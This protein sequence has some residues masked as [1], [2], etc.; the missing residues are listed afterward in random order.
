M[1][2]KRKPKPLKIPT[3][4]AGVFAIIDADDYDLV[5]D[6]SWHICSG[7]AT[8]RKQKNNKKQ[9]ILMHKL[10]CRVPKNKVVDHI[11][12]NKLDNR[13]CNLRA[14]TTMENA[15]N[16][17]NPYRGISYNK[18]YNRYIAQPRFNYRKIHLGSFK[19]KEE[20]LE[21]IQ[22]WRE[23][24]CPFSDEYK[25]A[26]KLEYGKSAHYS[27]TKKTAYDIL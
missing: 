12:R 26:Q 22:I 8:T 13:R 18:I 19:T 21:A 1:K 5:K 20:A 9:V 24:Y 15:Q 25:C 14:A 7:Y 16:K 3:S 6:Y 11:N 17:D 10:I 4:R 23:L 27:R 2:I